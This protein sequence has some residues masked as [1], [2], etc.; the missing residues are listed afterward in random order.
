MEFLHSSLRPPRNPK[1]IA[2]SGK[3]YE[4]MHQRANRTTYAQSGGKYR[5]K[6]VQPFELT[7]LVFLHVTAAIAWIGAHFFEMM[8]LHV[9]LKK[10]PQRT[11]LE[12]Y[13]GTLFRFN[14]ITG[15][16][17]ASTLYI[18]VLLAVDM[19]LG[20]LSYVFTT[21]F[22]LLSTL[23]VIAL[24]I[25]LLAP[26]KPQNISRLFN[27]GLAAAVAAGIAAL[28][29]IAFSMELAGVPSSSWGVAILAGGLIAILLLVIGAMQGIKRIQIG[30]LSLQAL[31][32]SDDALKKLEVVE[33]KMLR[34]VVPENIVALAV[35]ALMVYA[36]N[37]F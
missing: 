18:G 29:S 16:A 25:G 15:V 7:V 33:K 22:G 20:S 9:S 6:L 3:S 1:Q 21:P 4:K 2:R 19:Y 26:L 12:F 14:K 27:I 17:A 24:L 32:G 13:A 31:S 23:F 11:K 37:P 10:V 28:A 8:I 35:I 30:V 5:Y 36:A 34:M